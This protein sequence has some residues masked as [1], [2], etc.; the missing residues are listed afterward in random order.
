M[1]TT[2]R[3]EEKEK[4]VLSPV[5]LIA[6]AFAPVKDVRLT[7]T[8]VLQ[9]R[10]GTVLVLLSLGG[11]RLGGSALVQVYGQLGDDCGSR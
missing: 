7:T 9:D 11:Q 1:R 10:E 4:S 3:E 8:P 2:W 6:S 5:S